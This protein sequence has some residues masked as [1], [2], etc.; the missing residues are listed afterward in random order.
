MIR[1]GIIG[2]GGIGK[3]HAP[4]IAQIPGVEITSVCD[5]IPR[6]VD[7]IAGWTGAKPYSDYL[8]LIDEVDVA[9]IC[10][11]EYAHHPMAL[12]LLRAGKHVFC[13]KAMALTVAKADEMIAVSR[14]VN[15]I[16]AIGYCLRFSDWM[17]KCKDV[18][19]SGVLGDITKVWTTRMGYFPGPNWYGTQALSGGMVTSQLTH[20]LDWMRAMAG[21]VEW[22]VATG[23]T[24]TPEKTIFDNVSTLFGFKSGATGQAMTSWSSGAG[25][26]DAGILGTKGVLRTTQMGPISV[27]IIGQEPYAV[28]FEAVDPYLV[29]DTEF[30]SC[31]R[32]GRPYPLALEEARE[33]LATGFAIERAARTGQREYV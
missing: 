13:E 28:E 25:W 6:R 20:N 32:E 8:D 33:S 7:R 4:L 10:T 17:K 18:V 15:L 16:L 24:V 29:E 26:I 27:H 22:A 31:V 19:D 2:C 23:Q 11:P 5:I 12:T 21:D 9:W 14:E 3:C 1:A 30:I